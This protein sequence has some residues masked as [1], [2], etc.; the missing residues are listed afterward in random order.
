MSQEQNDTPSETEGALRPSRLPRVA[1]I[2]TC[3]L[4]VIAAGVVSY[5]FVR[6]NHPQPHSYILENSSRENREALISDLT[7]QL[8]AMKSD[9][10]WEKNWSAANDAD[11]LWPRERVLTVLAI[12]E[13]ALDHGRLPDSI[14]EL[15][16]SGKLT[17]DEVSTL[18]LRRTGTHWLLESTAGH[19]AAEGN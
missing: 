14:R 8:E 4:L 2:A 7:K 17:P 13:F 5:W 16:E 15:E 10:N 19:M 1:V 6:M 12:Q 11:S 9:P 18:Q 3:M